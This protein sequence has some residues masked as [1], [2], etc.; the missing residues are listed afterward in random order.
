MDVCASFR[1]SDSV[2]TLRK[3]TGTFIERVTF[4]AIAKSCRF[5]PTSNGLDLLRIG[6]VS[7]EHLIPSGLSQSRFLTWVGDM[8][9]KKTEEWLGS[10]FSSTHLAHVLKTLSYAIGNSTSSYSM[11]PSANDPPRLFHKILLY[12]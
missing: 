11:G 6:S 1:Y 2:V 10:T 12:K 7:L 4:T 8:L 3:L 9:L 5:V